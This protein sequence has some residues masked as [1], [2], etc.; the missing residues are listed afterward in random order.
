MFEC[1]QK[2]G[3]VSVSYDPYQDNKNDKTFGS[4]DIGEDGRNNNTKYQGFPLEV[5]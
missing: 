5:E 3:D 2:H 4:S 1:L